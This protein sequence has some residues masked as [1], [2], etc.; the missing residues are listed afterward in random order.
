MKWSHKFSK[1]QIPLAAKL[2]LAMTS[3]VTLSVGSATSVSIYRNHTIFRQELEQQAEVL[4][5]TLTTATADSLYFG[6]VELLDDIIDELTF[7]KTLLSS[8][9]YQKDGRIIAHTKDR[10]QHPFTLTTDPL[11]KKILR[12]QTILFDW[13]PDRLLAGKSVILGEEVIGAIAV[14]LSTTSLQQKNIDERNQ[15]VILG[16]ILGTIGVAISLWLSKS[17]TEPLIQMT[18]ATEY[19]TQGNLDRQIEVHSNDELSILANAFNA[20]TAKLKKVIDSLQQS[21]KLASHK[22]TQ[23]EETLKELQ[24]AKEKAEAANYA[25][26]Q[27]L[28]NMSHELRTPLN[29]ILGYV[30]ILRRDRTLTSQQTKGLNN[31]QLVSC[32]INCDRYFGFYCRFMVSFLFSGR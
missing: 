26:S 11:G 18:K 9:V 6:D 20:M 7:Q 32:L 5:N 15:S 14:E 17:I 12:S 30:Q 2:T 23:L 3:L 10:E 21:E 4:L 27:F 24:Q 16:L 8:S 25:K 29:G 1:L 28:S 19:L 13:Q 31:G 22:A